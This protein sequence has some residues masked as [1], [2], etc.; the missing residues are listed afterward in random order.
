MSAENEERRLDAARAERV[1]NRRR[2]VRIR[3]VVEGQRDGPVVRAKLGD[4]PAEDRTIAVE[5]AVRRAAE[6]DGAGA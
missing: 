4:R 2:R 3:A 1:E 6:E 5:G